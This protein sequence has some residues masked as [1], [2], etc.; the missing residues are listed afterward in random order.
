M[1]VAYAGVSRTVD[2]SLSDAVA[3]VDVAVVIPAF[4]EHN[5]VGPTVD[6]VRAALAGTPLSFEIVVIDDGSTDATAEQ[7]ERHGG[8]VIRLPENRGYGAALKTGIL[9]SRSEYVLII[10]ADGTYPPEAIPALLARMKDA[11]MAVGARAANDTSIARARRPAKRVL[12]LLASYLAG[13]RIPDLNSGLR[14]MRRSVLMEFLHILPSG[15][16]FTTTITLALLCNNYLVTYLP[17]AC[18]PRVGSSKLRAKEFTAFI[19]LVLRTVVLFN[20][21]KVFLPL[22]AALFLIGA[23]KF[24]YDLFLWNLSETAVMAFLAAIVV[25]SVGLLADM[26]ARVQLNQRRLL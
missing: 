21:L 3:S 13:R 23:A 10:D 1:A 7:A 25:W 15:F 11:D 14:V 26:I 4:N 5:G 19:M 6:R 2:R 17:I 18:A 24:T 12:S 22:G 20:P 9:Q 16:S 8:R